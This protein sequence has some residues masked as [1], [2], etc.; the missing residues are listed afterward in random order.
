MMASIP[1]MRSAP[2]PTP[3]AKTAPAGGDASSGFAVER[4]TVPG[5]P[6]AVAPPTQSPTPVDMLD[7]IAPQIVAP[8]GGEDGKE[9]DGAAP[10]K[11]DKTSTDDSQPE[12]AILIPFAQHLPTVP[13][14][15]IPPAAEGAPG[16]TAVETAGLPCGT[17]GNGRK[18]APTPDGPDASSGEN[19]APDPATAT[20]AVMKALLQRKPPSAKQVEAKAKAEATETA[21]TD[22]TPAKAPAPAAVQAAT[23]LPVADVPQPA[24]SP[25]TQPAP[26][27]EKTATVEATSTADLVAERKLDLARDGAWLDRLARDIARSASDDTPLRFRLHPQTLGSLH[28]ELQQGDR[29]T[30]VRLTVETEA[31]RQ[32]LTDAQ[33]RLTAEARAQ[34]VRIAETHVD[35]SGSGRNAPGDQRRQDE[36]RQTPM[37]RT[38]PGADANGSTRASP[39]A[40]LDRY[41]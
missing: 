35:L 21:K 6:C 11:A 31:A 33:P 26:A 34:G 7:G 9:G 27:A 30:A 16:A 32:I 29:G 25:T 14:P 28:V 1:N 5:G 36:A 38:V 3:A 2:L 15:Q 13:A 37:I 17:I 40:R 10:A 20:D 4:P 18:G 19:D 24:L 8:E 41:A 22:A 39:R 23:P 12:T